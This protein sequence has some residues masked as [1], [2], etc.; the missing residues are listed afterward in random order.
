MTVPQFIAAYY[1]HGLGALVAFWAIG[2]VISLIE[3][4]QGYRDYWHSRSLAT[5]ERKAKRLA[6][7]A[8][9]QRRIETMLADV[10]QPPKPQPTPAFADEA[11]HQP[12]RPSRV[13]EATVLITKAIEEAGRPLG[14]RE[15]ARVTQLPLTTV[16]RAMRRIA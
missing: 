16:H 5:A 11:R 14:V 13:D 9:V 1:L 8:R 3:H 6:E 12:V 2:T 15:A 4:W 10:Q 7:K